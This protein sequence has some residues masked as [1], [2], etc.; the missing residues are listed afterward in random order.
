MDFFD[1]ALQDLK[2]TLPS[3][4]AQ[5]ETS[6][7]HRWLSAIA[8][9]LDELAAEVES[10]YADQTLE[11]AEEPALRNEWAILYG[12]GAEQVLQTPEGL[13][14]YLR[15][16]AADDGTLNAAIE[17]LL[18]FLSNQPNA[19]GTLLTFPLDGSGLAFA[20]EAGPL[21]EGVNG[22]RAYLVFPADGSG[23]TFPADG[24]GLAFPSE[25]W[26]EV[27]ERASDE[28]LDVF[29]RDYLA[30]DRPAFQRAVKRLNSATGGPPTI[31][32][33]SEPHV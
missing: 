9:A 28:G 13:R 4:Y 17:V 15:A 8:D 1:G 10:I 33:T 32:E 7:L 14:S 26:V 12:A 18:G 27:F 2:D 31:T 6:E 30:F 25:G 3:W 24:S 20:P 11:T 5:A 22:Q 23:L 16:R 19:G 29:V 21:W